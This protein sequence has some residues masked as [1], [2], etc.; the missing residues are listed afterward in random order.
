MTA[1]NPS[2][3]RT[4]ARTYIHTRTL[5]HDVQTHHKIT[6]TVTASAST[7]KT[8]RN[9]LYTKITDD[10]Q[11][12]RSKNKKVTKMQEN[13]FIKQRLGMKNV[14]AHCTETVLTARNDQYTKVKM[15]IMFNC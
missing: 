12:V 13:R 10:S 9:F 2:N 6:S 14:T 5:T 4:Y 3:A 7:E 15:L 11:P 8:K 1:R